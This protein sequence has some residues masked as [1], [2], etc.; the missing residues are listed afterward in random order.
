MD[1]QF[2]VDEQGG[3]KQQDRRDAVPRIG[4]D[5]NPGPGE[6]VSSWMRGCRIR[7]HTFRMLEAGKLTGVRYPSPSHREVA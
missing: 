2:D 3:G 6:I 5:E 4:E 1:R 7:A